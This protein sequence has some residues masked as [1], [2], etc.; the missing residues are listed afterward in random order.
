MTPIELLNDVKARFPVLLHREDEA[1]NA[2]LKKAVGTY[3]ELAG[4]MAKVR[5]EEGDVIAG[6]C[7][8]PERFSTRVMVKDAHGSFVAS[9]VWADELE[10][11][12]AGGERFPL[13]LIYLEN[14]RDANFESVTLPDNSVSLIG[15]YLENL[16]ASPNAERQRRVAIA[17]KLD[18][19]DIPTEADLATRRTE[20][21]E[22]IKASQAMLP[23]MSF[24]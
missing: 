14:L 18:T 13:T 3:Q 12:L 4:F 10:L 23:M 7:T 11:S 6:K 17:G 2:L 21:E 19:T 5:I 9:D 1:L 24:L 20:L 22:K 15:D 16:I 8:V